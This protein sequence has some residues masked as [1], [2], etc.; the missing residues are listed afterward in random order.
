MT[1]QEIFDTVLFNLREQGRASMNGTDCM[2]RGGNGAKCA[3]GWLIPDEHYSE[4]LEDINVMGEWVQLTL[5]HAGIE[6]TPSTLS[7]LSDMQRAHDKVLAH[8]GV[9]NWEARM[10]GIALDYDLHYT[11]PETQNA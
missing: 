2:Y 1:Q 8:D 5:Q 4:E 10:R 11:P 6:I 9:Q 3:V 7:L